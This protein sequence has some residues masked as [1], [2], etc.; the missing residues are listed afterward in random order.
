[1]DTGRPTL[2]SAATSSGDENYLGTEIDAGFTYRFAPNVAFDLL[3]GYLIA[4]DA[5][6]F[7]NLEPDDIWKVAARMRV[8]W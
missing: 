8:T 4:G 6:G 3:G 5:R 1:V 2:N 7:N